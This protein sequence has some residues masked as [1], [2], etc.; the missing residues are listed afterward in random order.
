MKK[1]VLLANFI[2]KGNY[3]CWPGNCRKYGGRIWSQQRLAP[4]ESFNSLAGAF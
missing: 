4:A 2:F 1:E 3:Y